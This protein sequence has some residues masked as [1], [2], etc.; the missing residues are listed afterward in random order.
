MEKN[1]I[2]S[3]RF[4]SISQE[5]S[6]SE[7]IEKYWSLGGYRQIGNQFSNMDKFDYLYVIDKDILQKRRA[8]NDKYL[9]MIKDEEA[10]HG[11]RF[12]SWME[13]PPHLDK[14]REAYL[15]ELEQLDPLVTNITG[16]FDAGF[17]SHSQ[18]VSQGVEKTYGLTELPT[19]WDTLHVRFREYPAHADALL[20]RN[21]HNGTVEVFDWTSQYNKN[22]Q[23]LSQ[24][25]KDELEHDPEYWRRV[26]YRFIE[27][28]NPEYSYP[29]YE[30]GCGYFEAIAEEYPEKAELPLSRADVEQ[31]RA[32]GEHSTVL[33][34]A[35]LGRGLS[36]KQLS[37]L[38]Y[39]SDALIALDAYQAAKQDMHEDIYDRKVRRPWARLSAE[40]FGMPAPKTRTLTSASLSRSIS[41]DADK[42]KIYTN[43]ERF[44]DSLTSI[45]KDTALWDRLDHMSGDTLYSGLVR[46]KIES[47]AYFRKDAQFGHFGIVYLREWM[48]VHTLI[49]V[50]IDDDTPKGLDG[51]MPVLKVNVRTDGSFQDNETVKKL[52]ETLNVYPQEFDFDQKCFFETPVEDAEL[53]EPSSGLGM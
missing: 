50:N 16:E 41:Y 23:S 28:W 31:I 48:D 8:A 14:A 51:D 44:F 22:M 4:P 52:L 34:K 47:C 45:P 2:T 9:A 6:I 27:E 19:N 30:D 36:P 32:D 38:Y 21:N 25:I 20:A 10:K 39:F 7:F 1:Q 3:S 40:G 35:W 49:E 18:H 12:V 5:M 26:D 29:N 43:V 13:Y 46:D 24:Y 42:S 11:V 37:N 17:V 15:N 53:N 33:A